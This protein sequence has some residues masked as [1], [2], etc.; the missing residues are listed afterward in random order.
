MNAWDQFGLI[1]GISLAFLIVLQTAGLVIGRRIGRYNVVDVTWGLG[2]IGIA[3]IAALLGDGDPLR[4]WLLVVLVTIWAARLSWHVHRK[5]KGKGED[6][7]YDELLDRTGRDIP[8][9]IRKI[10][11]VQGISQWFVSLPIQVSAVVGSPPAWAW[12]LVV[13]GVALWIV[14]QIFEAVGDHQLRA[15]KS[16]PSNKGKVMDRGLWAWTRH[17]NYFGDS[18][19]W[20]GLY[21]I[22]ATAWPAALMI[23]SPIAMTYFLVYATGARLLERHMEQRPGYREYQQRTSYFIPRPPRS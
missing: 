22:S 18:A 13:I 10:F 15:F 11:G 4:R 23:L 17:P 8:T 2:F 16:D 6:P 1:T 7:R 20:W 14:G 5:T 19:V 9:V 3:W 12:A 21:L